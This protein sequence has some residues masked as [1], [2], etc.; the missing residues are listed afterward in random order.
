[1]QRLR[2]AGEALQWE[3]PPPPLPPGQRGETLGSPGALGSAL[4]SKELTRGVSPG[5]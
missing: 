5:L 3:A 4:G 2:G 1:M